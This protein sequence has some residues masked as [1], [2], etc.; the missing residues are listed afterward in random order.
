MAASA[1]LSVSELKA[2]ISVAVA[3]VKANWR[4]NWPGN[5]RQKR[6]GNE[7]RA[8]AE[9]DGDHRHGDFFHRLVGRLLGR[10]AVLDPAF[11][12]FDDHDRVI[13]HDADGQHQAEER[14]IVERDSPTSPS[15]RT[16]RSAKPARRSAG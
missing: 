4:K 10:E 7:H 6:R 14:E 5:A 15:R 1:G 3:I 9:G 12:V 8:Q 13:D 11:H 16:C 2:E